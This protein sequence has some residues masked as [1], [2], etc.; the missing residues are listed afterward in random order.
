MRTTIILLCVVV[1]VLAVAVAVLWFDHEK[2]SGA[3][4]PSQGM[5]L[6]NEP[7][8][9]VSVRDRDPAAANAYVDRR[10][11]DMAQRLEALSAEVEQLKAS[12]NRSSIGAPPPSETEFMDRHRA[13]VVQIMDEEQRKRDWDNTVKSVQ[14]AAVDLASG[15]SKPEAAKPLLR[16]FGAEY[17]RRAGS[18]IDDARTK[19]AE[20]SREGSAEYQRW[21]RAWQ[22]LDAWGK[23]RF[24]EIDSALGAETWNL[25]ATQVGPLIYHF[26]P[27]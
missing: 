9:A 6:A 8:A 25:F 15:C 26:N 24:G 17:M 14:T 4:H 10:F 12:T 23:G 3:A 18:I 21:E 1:G 16:E 19:W 2:S 11:A 20:V 5:D 27:R 13:S 7:A 22:D